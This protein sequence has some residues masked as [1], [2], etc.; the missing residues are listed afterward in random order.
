MSPTSRIRSAALE[1]NIHLVYFIDFWLA[2]SAE[3]S[4]SITLGWDC[5]RKTWREQG[6]WL[7]TSLL[8]A[9]SGNQ[10]NCEGSSAEIYSHPLMNRAFLSPILCSCSSCRPLVDQLP[11]NLITESHEYT[12]GISFSFL[13]SVSHGFIFFRFSGKS[14]WFMSESVLRT[15]SLAR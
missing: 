8:T 15:L 7:T 4:T 14:D 11:G 13:P 9:F 12:M 1:D 5:T 3:H 2:Q 6:V 10:Q